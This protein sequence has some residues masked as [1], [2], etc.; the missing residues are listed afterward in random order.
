MQHINPGRVCAIVSAA[1][2][3]LVGAAAAAAQPSADFYKD[4]QI[5]FIIGYNP[6]GTYD[7]YSRL[8]APHLARHIP[9]RPA[10]VPRN[11]P[12]IGSLKAASFLANQAPRD[13]T[14]IGMIGQSMAL[15]QVLKNPA[16]DFDVRTFGW[17]GRLS[18]VSEATV[19]WHT[20]PVKTLQ[21]AQRLELI[22]GATSA[23]STSDGLPKLMN[24]L[25]GT[26][27]KVVL[28]YQ[29]TTGA[30]L[31]MERGEVHGS[32][33][34]LENLL[35]GKPEWLKENKV[36]VLVQYSQR[37]HQVFPNVP[38]MVESARNADDR[39]LLSLYGST[40]EIG[41]SIM[42]PPELPRDR[43]ALLQ[44]AFGDMV[45][46][47]IFIAEVK[48]RQMEFDPMS[49]EEL[50]ALIQETLNVSPAVAARA[51]AARE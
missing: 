47:P 32:H 31:A 23:R 39:Q 16:V 43:L 17:L 21:D 13:G 14:A 3:P 46:D 50:F 40:A 22:L 5:S 49:G 26:K 20:S 24:T 15:E 33:V 25:G 28:G 4:K 7:V 38:A 34:T 19:A 30:M 35:I 48:K 10:I 2:L 8:V 6:G 45:R 41:R 29:G 51:A 36:S 9:G 1:V 12:G 18:S 44:K 37:R 27:F 11:M 42:T